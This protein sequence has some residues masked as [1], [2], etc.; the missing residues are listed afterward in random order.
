MDSS[1]IQN[2]GPCDGKGQVELRFPRDRAAPQPHP[3]L[4]MWNTCLQE[5]PIPAHHGTPALPGPRPEDPQVVPP[6]ICSSRPPR[7]RR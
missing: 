7:P 6:Q 2:L 5:S 4:S 1:R 3:G